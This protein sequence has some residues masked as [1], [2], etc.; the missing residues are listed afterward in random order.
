MKA[1]VN[2][3]VHNMPMAKVMAKPS[4]N[5]PDSSTDNV[6]VITKVIKNPANAPKI[7]TTKAKPLCFKNDFLFIALIIS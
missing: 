2:P 4:K 3:K 5:N 7:L 1:V 6:R